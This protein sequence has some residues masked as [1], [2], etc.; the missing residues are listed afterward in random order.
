MEA[1][2]QMVQKKSCL[3]QDLDAAK[4]RHLQREILNIAS[5]AAALEG[6]IAREY[7]LADRPD[8]AI[9]NLISQASCYGDASRLIEARRVLEIALVHARGKRSAI[10]IQQ[11]LSRIPESYANPG[12]VFRRAGV[13]ISGNPNLRRPQREAYEAAFRHFSRSKAHAII[14]LPVGCGKTG[15]MSILPFRVANGRVLAVAP[16]L[17]IRQNLFSSFD[18]T[19]SDSFLRNRGVLSNGYGPSCAVLDENA[20]IRDCDAAS[21]VVTNIQQL[22]AN[23]AD[24]WLAKLP[25]DF[26]DLIV[27]DEGHHNVAASWKQTLMQFPDAK[28]ASFTATPFRADGQM[29]EGNRIY[30]FPIADAIKE[31]YIKDL[32]SHRLE[33]QELTFTYRGEKRVHTLEEVLKLKEEQ[34]FS[35]GIALSSECNKSIVDHSLQCMEQLR[36]S[37]RAKHQVIAAACSIDHARAIR[38]L[39]DERNYK[40][41]VI[42]SDLPSE[43]ADRIRGALKRFELDAIVHVQMLA[44]GADYPNL[45]VAAIFRPFRHLV[46]YVQFVGR[47]MRVINQDSPGDPDNRGYVVSHVGLNVDRWWS[48]LKEFDEDDQAFFEQLAT[49]EKE[50]ALPGEIGKP[51]SAA[52]ILPRRYFQPDMVVIEEVI[53]RYVK[54]RFLPE[55]VRA[56]AD[57]VI[58]AMSLRGVDLGSLGIDREALEERIKAQFSQTKST[59]AVIEHPIQPQRARQVAKQRLDER[60]GAGGKQLLNELGLSVAGFDLPRLFPQTAAMNNLAAAI[61]LLNL[62]VQAYLNVGSQERDILTTEQMLNAHDNMDKLVDAIAVRF[63]EKRKH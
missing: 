61:I 34:W 46:P 6:R 27:L 52:H 55:D 7:I 20:N 4:H 42:H 1:I 59:G 23:K 9:A 41:E 31:G 53:A 56:I 14:Q 22:V 10:W 63:R 13:N 2:R 5:E 17:E 40:A 21:I 58:N 29:V 28:V 30:R 8:D 26:F 60:V 19:S 32:A 47:I 45:S 25:P 48:E 54:E 33:P 18:Y 24:K 50:F 62:E 38:A 43:E 16:N 11:E 3:L 39:Y 37:G 36:A 51:A 44:E 57:D 12:K 49:S 15:T 35:K